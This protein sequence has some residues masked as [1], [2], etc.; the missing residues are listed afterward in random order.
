MSSYKRVIIFVIFVI[1]LLGCSQSKSNIINYSY[2]SFEN[3]DRDILFALEYDRQGDKEKARELYLTLYNNTL[4]DEYLLEYTKLSFALQKYDDIVALV[5]KNKEKIIRHK[6]Q[7]Y[8]VYIL[9]LLQLEKFDMALNITSELIKENNSDLNHELLGSIYLQKND[10]K[11]AKREFEYIYKNSFNQSALVELINIMYI[12]LDEK[13]EAIKLLES[14]IKLYGCSNITCSKLLNIYQE[15]NNLDGVISVLKKSYYQYKDRSNHLTMDKIYKLLMY[16][17]EKKGVNEAILFL[18]NSRAN[19]EKLLELYRNSNKLKKA[20]LLAKDLYSRNGNID[21][22][23]QIAILEFESAENKKEVLDSV[24]KK[25][26]DV[27]VVL[28]NHIYQN[29]LGYLL[30]DYNVD[31][32][33]GVALVKEALKKAPNNLAYLDSLAWGQYKLK[34]CKEAYKNMKKVVDNVGLKDEE[35][36]SHWK[37]IKECS[38]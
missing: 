35:I 12:Y 7:I 27:L 15:E 22:L 5:E 25:F 17:L 34:Q 29:Y 6:S 30:I 11:N 21:Y 9:T 13:E 23:A 16:Y 1:F 14:H 31:I 28:D 32:K 8:R 24:I 20:Y 19:D 33:R 18:E 2:K 37:E 36:K 26:N 10:F 4:K 38:K 3:E